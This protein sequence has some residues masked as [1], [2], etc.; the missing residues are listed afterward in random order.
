[1]F[2]GKFLELRPIGVGTHM[3]L[4]G[5][6]G[7]RI[8]IVRVDGS[9]MDAEMDAVCLTVIVSSVKVQMKSTQIDFP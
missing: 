3:G 6:S 1:M 2:T 8:L 4:L 7:V 5:S 9:S